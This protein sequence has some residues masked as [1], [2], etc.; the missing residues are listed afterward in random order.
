MGKPTAGNGM[1]S[2][3]DIDRLVHEPAAFGNHGIAL[4]DRKR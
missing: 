1:S 4:C 2:L 3:V